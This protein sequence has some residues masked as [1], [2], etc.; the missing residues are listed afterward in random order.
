MLNLTHKKQK[1]G[2]EKNGDK[3]GKALYK[4]MNNAVYRKTM[5]NLRNRIDVKLVYT[6][7]KEKRK[8]KKIKNGNPNQYIC[9]TKYLTMI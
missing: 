3:N 6:K 8:K 5:E 4:L 2:A 9:H 7:K 1:I